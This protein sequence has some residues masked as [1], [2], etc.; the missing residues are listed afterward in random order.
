MGTLNKAASEAMVEVGVDG[1]TDVTGFG[2]LGHLR[3]ANL[4]SGVG[5]RLRMSE[6]PVLPAAWGLVSQG[7]A[8]GGA[9]R[10]RDYVNEAVVFD[11]EITPDQQVVVC[12][13]QTSGG[14]LMFV[15][16]EKV[17]ALLKALEEKGVETR[18]VIGEFVA[19]DHGRIW[20]EP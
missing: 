8:P 10:N 3:E 16:A 17:D 4:A 14:L 1:C 6:I 20:V 13:P 15:P 18:A 9:R 2:L 7:I 11:T 12:D 5:A 19:D